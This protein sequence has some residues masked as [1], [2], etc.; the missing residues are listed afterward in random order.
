MYL[1]FLQHYVGTVLNL[2]INLFYHFVYFN[3]QNEQL[4]NFF[5]FREEDTSSSSDEEELQEA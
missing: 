1:L 2:Y 5:K 3:F 4:N